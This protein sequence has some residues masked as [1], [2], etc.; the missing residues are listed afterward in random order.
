MLAAAL[1]A[2]C[3]IVLIPFI[4]RD[5]QYVYDLDYDLVYDLVHDL[6]YYDLVYDLVPHGDKLAIQFDTRSICNYEWQ[7][8]R[9]LSTSSKHT[10]HWGGAAINNKVLL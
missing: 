3:L 4:C 6:V 1:Y 10:F 8:S 9:H 5:Y 2:S 7:A